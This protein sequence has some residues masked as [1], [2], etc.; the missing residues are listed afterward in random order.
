MDPLT[1]SGSTEPS[2]IVEAVLGA[3]SE[4]ARP[5]GFFR[6]YS[7]N[8]PSTVKIITVDPAGALSLQRHQHRDELWVV[9]DAG[10]RVEIDGE[11][12]EPEPGAE[13]VIP[14]GSVHRL[15]SAGPRGRVLE[16]AF[17]HFDEAD[18]E[19]LDDVYGR[20]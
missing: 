16:V 8:A 5:W 17:G 10:L 3:I 9:L 2:A 14:R 15:S 13:F 20:G 7:H 11:I 12:A 6:Q 18:I 4:D 1:A 19:R